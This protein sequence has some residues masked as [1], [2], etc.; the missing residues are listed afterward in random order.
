[1]VIGVVL[2]LAGGLAVLAG[3]AER[4]RFRQLRQHG[5]RTWAMAVP[6]PAAEDEAQRSPQ[7]PRTQ[8]QF[9]LT[10]GQVFEQGYPGSLRKARRVKPGQQILV[11]YDPQDPQDVLVYGRST[12][13]ADAAFIAAGMFFILVGLLIAAF[14]R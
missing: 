8:I 1:M 5:I 13:L 9:S 3:W 6:R 14:G 10:D 4:R 7:A 2:A 12:R 11:W